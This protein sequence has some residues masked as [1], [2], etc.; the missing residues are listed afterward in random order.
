MSDAPT[1]GILAAFDAALASLPM[2]PHRIPTALPAQPEEVPSLAVLLG[3]E[4]LFSE[5]HPDGSTTMIDG[6][7]ALR[8]SVVVSAE[9]QALREEIAW[10]VYEAAPFDMTG[11][12]TVNYVSTE[13]A[14]GAAG[15]QTY[16][17]ARINFDVLYR[18]PVAA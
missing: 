9:T 6:V 3:D 12:V 11:V 2:Q 17:S 16:F 13:R 10:A 5:S 8:V 7:R 4:S 14:D 18:A 1:L 15:S